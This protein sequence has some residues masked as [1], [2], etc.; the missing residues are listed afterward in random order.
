ME[1]EREDKPCRWAAKGLAMRLGTGN[2]GQERK[3]E[4]TKSVKK[5]F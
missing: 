3:V 5:I 4:M 2:G 1:V